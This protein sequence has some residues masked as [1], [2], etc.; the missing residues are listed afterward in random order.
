MA[1]LREIDN[2]V[3]KYS[4]G[5]RALKEETGLTTETPVRRK[6]ES[7]SYLNIRLLAHKI[8]GM[9]YKTPQFNSQLLKYYINERAEPEYLAREAVY[10]VNPYPHL[11][12]ST[13]TGLVTIDATEPIDSVRF[14]AKFGLVSQMDGDAADI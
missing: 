7:A 14:L 11:K 10:A 1:T 5:P 8:A 4:F 2:A 12:F 3:G 6:G 9:H 13:R